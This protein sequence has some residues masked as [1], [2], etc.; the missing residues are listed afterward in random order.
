MASGEI[1]NIHVGAKT[2]SDDNNLHDQLKQMEMLQDG[3]KNI[4]EKVQPIEVMTPQTTLVHQNK[5]A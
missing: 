2:Q 1:T 5:E 3:S 4:I